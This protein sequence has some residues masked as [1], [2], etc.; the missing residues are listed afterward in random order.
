MYATRARSTFGHYR[1]LG[2]VGRGGMADVWRAEWAAPSGARLPVALKCMRAHL[3]DDETA[4]RLFHG[5][6]R[7]ALRLDHPNIVR[8]LDAGTVAGQPFLALELIDGVELGALWRAATAPLPLGFCL[9][10]ARELCAALAYA[11]ALSDEEGHFI[12]LVHRDVSPSNVMLGFDG[13]VK[14]LDFGVAHARREDPAEATLAG[15][16]RGKVGYLAPEILSCEPY[17]HRADLFSLGVMLYELVTHTRLFEAH[18]GASALAANR[19]CQV[20]PPSLLNPAV[21]PIVDHIVLRALARDPNQRYTWA[22]ELMSNLESALATLPWSR[23]DTAA[24]IAD[25]ESFTDELEVAASQVQS[26]P[27]ELPTILRDASLALDR[28]PACERAGQP[29]VCGVSTTV[30]KRRPSPAHRH[31]LLIGLAAPLLIF[32]FLGAGSQRAP[33]TAA[34]CTPAD[35]PPVSTQP[36]TFAFFGAASPRPRVAANLSQPAGAPP[37]RLALAGAG[38]TRSHATAAARARGEVSLATTPSGPPPKPAEAQATV[39]R[40]APLR[41]QQA[42]RGASLRLGLDRKSLINP[43]TLRRGGP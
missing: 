37:P 17:D 31:W 43:F 8:A 38:S 36:S 11:H 14:L 27:I 22:T 20:S 13:T 28:T 3:A 35:A 16:V 30:G 24:L 33:A 25:G 19:A 23:E 9:Y 32:A 39:G 12:G 1:L 18:A 34:T 5:E 21:P 26:D 4:L 6:A 41:R 29:T 7:L 10:V 42:E 40:P 15:V 2:T